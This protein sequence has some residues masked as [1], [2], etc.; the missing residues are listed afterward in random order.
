[1]WLMPVSQGCE[2]CTPCGSEPARDS[3]LSDTSML[4]VPPSSRAGSL[5]QGIFCDCTFCERHRSNVGAG[6][7]ANAVGQAPALSTDTASSRAS[8]LPQ[9]ICTSARYFLISIWTLNGFFA[10]H[11]KTLSVTSQRL[12]RLAPLPTGTPESAGLCVLGV[13]GNLVRITDC[14]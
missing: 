1:M 13:A 6:L 11:L 14:Q 10:M 8:P 9:G 2:H 12:Q 3:S 5:P 7:L 4:N